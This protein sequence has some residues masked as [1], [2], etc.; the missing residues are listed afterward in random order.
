M[1]R[2][3]QLWRDIR[4]PDTLKINKMLIKESRINVDDINNDDDDNRS[5]NSNDIILSR[6]FES[7][8]CHF[9]SSLINILRIKDENILLCPCCGFE[10]CH[11]FCVVRSTMLEV[12]STLSWM[13][14]VNWKPPVNLFKLQ[15][16]PLSEKE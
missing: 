12:R 8:I 11:P 13:E 15:F 3:D 16:N 14:N 1:G 6:Y 9:S 2:G 5:I 7:M 4:V 10:K